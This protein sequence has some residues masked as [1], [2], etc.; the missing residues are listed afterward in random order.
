VRG[1]RIAGGALAAVALATAACAAEAPTTGPV[2]VGGGGGQAAG[3]SSE[4]APTAQPRR[5]DPRRGGFEVGFGEFAVTLE[6][7][8]IRPGPVTFVVRNGGEMIHGFEMEI[9]SEDDDNSG[10]G[11]G[12]DDG[13]KIEQ[14]MFGPGETIRID[15]DLAQGLYKV[16]CWVANHDDLGM[17]AL[18]EVRPD[19]PKVL[20]EPAA[21]GGDAVQIQGF[22]FDPDV[23]EVTAATEVTWT[24]GDPEAH[25]VTAD[26]GSFD[27]GPVDPDGTFA[28]SFD[29][30]GSFTY[31]CAIHPSMKGTVRVG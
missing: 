4:S 13:F 26:D 23:I 10:P 30:A 21:G 18:L 7:D 9:E 31:F 28:A 3:T 24:N 22:A 27:S 12:D 17:E 8:A 2:E 1:R 16:E 11:G 14:P 15:L 29:Q 19:A 6:A 25:T 20:R 5:V